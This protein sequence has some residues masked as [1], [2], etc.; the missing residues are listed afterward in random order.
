MGRSRPWLAAGGVVFS[1]AASVNA[2]SSGFWLVGY[3]PGGTDNT[4][5]ALSQDGSVAQGGG[6][7]MPGFLNASFSW[8]QQG[9]RND[10][11]TGAGM[12]WN[13]VTSCTD[14]AGL[15]VAGM[16]S[17][18]SIASQ[19]AFRRV[20]EGPLEDLGV[21]PGEDW[22]FA[23]GISGDGQIVVGR[24]EHGPIVGKF[25]RAF[26]WTPSGGMQPL[27]GAIPNSS[28]SD[29]RAIS[30]DG[31]T[32]VGENQNEFGWYQAFVWREDE[33]MEVLPTLTGSPSGASA[34]AVNA[35][36][37]VVVG[38]SPSSSGKSHST[39]WTN[40]QPQDLASNFAGSHSHSY[41]VGDDGNRVGGAYQAGGMSLAFVWTPETGMIN[42]HEYLALHGVEVPAGFHLEYV[43]AISGDGLTIGGSARNLTTNNFEGW[44]AT[45][46]GPSTCF[47]DCDQS[48]Q[49]NI[50]DF[51]CF[52]TYFVLGDQKADCDQSGRLDID[53]LICFQTYFAIGC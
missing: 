9:G 53:D 51:I 5:R 25:Q 6:Y 39:R 10:W 24:C 17:G 26:R 3:P 31:T 22:S 8:T 38:A 11:G 19:R 48:S 41:S 34:N 12:P 7:G 15:I 28:K 50:D 23:S 27:S 40:G 2:Q 14:N 42:A 37:T 49:L 18:T 4:I 13:N 52:Q 16:I 36:G 30:R 35:D 47:P 43:Y 45:I 21:L 32:I 29:A 1:F 20:G 46:P 33:G 44:V